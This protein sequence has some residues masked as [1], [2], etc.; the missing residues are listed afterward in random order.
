M[1][2]RVGFSLSEIREMLD[3]YDLKDGQVTQ[4]R[5]ALDKFGAQ[6]SLLEEQRKEID[7]A[8]TELKRTHKVVEGMLKEREKEEG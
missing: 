7:Q 5:V 6:I 1:G 2:K 8:L 3:L 4:L